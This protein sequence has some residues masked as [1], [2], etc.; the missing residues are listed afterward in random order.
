MSAILNLLQYILT[1]QVNAMAYDAGYFYP[2]PAIKDA[3]LDKA[4]QASQDVIKG[5]SRDWYDALIEKMP[6]ATPLAPA[7]MVKAFD[8]WD[9]EV[10]SG[11]YAAK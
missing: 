11:K 9:R 8:I 6:K 7:D 2:G 10:G 1:P 5:F 3:T 4:P